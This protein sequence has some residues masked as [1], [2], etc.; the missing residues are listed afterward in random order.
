MINLKNFKVLA[1]S[2]C[3]LSSGFAFNSNVVN[4]KDFIDTEDYINSPYA[5]VG[6]MPRASG[7]T[8]T[9]PAA[10]GSASTY[11]PITGTLNSSYYNKTITI[12]VGSFSNGMDSV[13]MGLYVDGKF[14][15]SEERIQSGGTASF[16]FPSSGN[17]YQIRMS[18]YS[19]NR[20]TCSYSTSIR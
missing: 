6:V 11:A 14:Q 10:G 2:L 12:S 8:S 3:V 15:G 7:V 9:L 17:G 4:A 20:G 16:Q 19:S 1:L 13:N 18:T 5:K